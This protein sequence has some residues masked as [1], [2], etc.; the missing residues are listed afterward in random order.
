MIV[1]ITCSA[2]RSTS[3]AIISN[4]NDNDRL[5]SVGMLT[6][7]SYGEIIEM[8]KKGPITADEVLEISQI[9]SSV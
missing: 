2:C 3:L 8:I 4:G 9:I 7:L 5:I 6:D 1:H